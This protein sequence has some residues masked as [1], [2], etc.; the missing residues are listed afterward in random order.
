[1][2]LKC[3]HN[4][5]RKYFLK[6]HQINIIRRSIRRT[7]R[8]YFLRV[9]LF[10]C[11]MALLLFLVPL[12]VLQIFDF[13]HRLPIMIYKAPNN[14]FYEI[15]IPPK[16][17]SEEHK[18]FKYRNIISNSKGKCLNRKMARSEY[19]RILGKN[20][21]QEDLA[22]PR[23]LVIGAS[24]ALG[25]AISRKFA[26]KG[27]PFIAIN[28]INE[29]DFTSPDS[30]IPF[31]N[32]TIKQ[33]FIVYQPPLTHHS[34][35][36]GS[37]DLNDI[38][39]NYIRGITSFLNDRE[40]PFVFAPV[41]PI[42][43]ETMTTALRN[44]GCVVEVPYL[45]DKDAFYDL[46]NPTMRAVRECRIS[47]R[48]DIEIIPTKSYHSIRADDASKFVRH[49]I[50]YPDDIKRGRFAIYGA[51]NITIEEAVKTAVKAANLDHCDLHF[52]QTPHKIDEFPETQHKAL[53]GEEDDNVTQMLM[54]EFS[55]FNRTEKETKYFSFVIVG[56]H[57]NFSKGFERR[58][59]NFLDRISGALE[60]V[61]LADIEI[62]FVDYATDLKKGNSLLNQ[63]FN[64]SE[65]LKGKVQ[66]IIV[67]QSAHYKILKKMNDQNN[68][69]VKIS[70][71]EYLAKNIGIRRAKGKFV[72]TTNPD[73]L[74]SDEL[75]ELIAARQ[76]NTALLYRA[77]RWDERDSTYNNKT[78]DE[79]VQGLNEPW[80]MRKYDINQRCSFGKQ[81]FSIIESFDSFEEHSAPC[82]A[83][84]FILLSKKMWDAIDGFNEI[85]ANPNVDV[86]FISKMMRLIPGFAQMFTHPLILHQKHPKKNIFRPSVENHTKY[87]MEYC[88]H[89]NCLSCGNYDHTKNWGM[90]DESFEISE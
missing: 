9:S 76:F 31:E 16:V 10:I 27:K 57:D 44:G 13:F 41:S 24:T 54:T 26:Y 2:G 42:S 55:G 74:L 46:E 69:S 14:A 84:D 65:N 12:L 89:G 29:I 4:L 18:A 90:S 17:E 22:E 50:K 62:I 64:I 71:L 1:M 66:Y 49:Q 75:F 53:I 58:A 68:S 63:V 88:C 77:T 85:P 35:T 36:D 11:F 67:P 80:T 81:R 19:I 34:T 32:V 47:G 8:N 52:H 6:F 79:I 39:T 15:V 5:F 30:L 70:F 37:Q 60:K 78:F 51:S 21:R 73:D 33:A 28:G 3:N 20:L 82:G 61:P 83:G 86:L 45:V 40:I 87:M 72:L 43:E 59:Q 38:A 25:A 7:R 23:Y 56:R 48:T